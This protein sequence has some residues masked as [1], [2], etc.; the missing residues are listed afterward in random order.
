MA[1]SVPPLPPRG[2]PLRRLT[3]AAVPACPGTRRVLAAI[4]D[5]DSVRKVLGALGLSTAVPELAHVPRAG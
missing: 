1:A 3:P 2:N 4:H 5:P